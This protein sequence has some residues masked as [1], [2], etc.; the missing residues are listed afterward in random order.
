MLAAALAKREQ[1]V[2]PAFTLAAIQ[3]GLGQHGAALEWLERA[4]D[5]RLLGYYMPSVDPVYDS[6]RADPRFQTLLRRMHLDRER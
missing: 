1:G 5:E 3:M 4:A 6:I 2:Y